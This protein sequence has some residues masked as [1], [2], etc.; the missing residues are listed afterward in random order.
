MGLAEGMGIDGAQFGVIPTPAFGDVV[1][2]RR[3]IQQLGLA[4]VVED[5]GRTRKL[6]GLV[7]GEAVQVGDHVQGVLVHGVGVEQVVLHA[8]GDL[9]EGRQVA[10]KHAIQVHAGQRFGHARAAHQ[11][12]ERGPGT[13]S[14]GQRP[15]QF[16]Q[17]LF[18]GRRSGG[19]QGHQVGMVLPAHEQADDRGRVIGQQPPGC[20]GQTPAVA[21]EAAGQRRWRRCRLGTFAQALG[22][23][24]VD[25]AHAQGGT[26]VTLHHLFHG[27]VLAM[28]VTQAET[29]RQ[30][31]LVVEQQ[32]LLGPARGQVQ[33]KAQPLQH[34]TAGGQLLQAA[35]TDQTTTD[36]G[37]RL[38]AAGG[39][40]CHP[41]QSLDV[42]QAAGAFLQVR[43]QVVA[44]VAVTA[45]AGAGLGQFGI[46]KLAHR[47]DPGGCHPGLQCRCGSGRAGQQP[48]LH[49]R[50]AHGDVGGGL[51]VA[52]G[53]AAYGMAGTQVQIP[54]GRDERLDAPHLRRRGIGIDQDHHIQVRFR[55][56]LAAA[57]AAGG[58]QG[59]RVIARNFGLRRGGGCRVDDL[60]PQPAQPAIKS[61][62]TSS[63]QILHRHTGIELRGLGFRQRRHFLAQALQL[64]VGDRPR[65]CRFLPRALAP[66]AVIVARS[67]LS[68]PPARSG[69]RPRCR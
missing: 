39:P 65:H 57:V 55:I 68:P 17:S 5:T 56:Q 62:G 27:A 58:E 48:G 11:I 6:V 35:P 59:R 64:M 7:G 52:L 50:R 15:V 1:E 29:L 66:V 21:M 40:L 47:P 36:P 51:G 28:L 69:Y 23:P 8:P 67:G 33:A 49:Q 16:R 12:Q 46:N 18:Q 4:Q 31:G 14:A 19:G 25:P 13:G 44:G 63:Q 38:R 43:L 37:A 53:Q 2:Q 45:V 41:G 60:L 3:Q 61:G 9:G 34:L 42:A 54:Q 24:R 10:A 20:Q 30:A 32:P 22:D 26:E